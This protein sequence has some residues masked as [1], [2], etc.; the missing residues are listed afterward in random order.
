M[1]QSKLLLPWGAATLIEHVIH[2][3]RSSQVSQVLVVVH[4]DDQEL[5]ELAAAA[6]ATVVRPATPPPEMKD[7]V[8]AALCQI[9]LEFRPTANDAWLLAPADLPGLTSAVIDRL[10]TS[11]EQLA[12]TSP[13]PPIVAAAQDGRLRH[14]VL[15]PWRLAAEVE[16]LTSQ[17][18]LDTIVGRH[19]VEMVELAG[20]MQFDDLD[21]PADY[22]RFRP[23]A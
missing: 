6:G 8:L 3:W 15:F 10:L 16:Q 13:T 14:P 20:V 12:T 11:Y 2:V 17:Q 18:G 22:D 5:D 23:Q 9:E 4:P 19:R 21:T 1:G 7:S